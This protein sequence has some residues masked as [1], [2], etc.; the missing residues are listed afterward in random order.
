MSTLVSQTQNISSTVAKNTLEQLI[1][2]TNSKKM[3][4]HIFSDKKEYAWLIS[5]DQMNGFREIMGIMDKN[6]DNAIKEEMLDTIALLV[7]ADARTE[8][9][10]GLQEII[11]GDWV[12]VDD[13]GK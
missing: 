13:L 9:G 4:F 7:N 2:I 1:R 3:P 12:S 11:A 6:E 10:Q 8:I 5:E